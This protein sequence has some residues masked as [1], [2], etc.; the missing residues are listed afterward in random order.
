MPRARAIGVLAAGLAL[1]VLLMPGLFASLQRSFIYFPLGQKAPP[2]A[3]VLP[4]AE[5]VRFQTEDGLTLEAW[6]RAG[7]AGAAT[8]LV[9]N[10]NAGDRSHR[11][12]LA[13]ALA[14]EGFGVLLFDYRGYAG[15]PGT[16]TEDGLMADARAALDHLRSR[17]DVDP[18]R[19][20]YFGESLGA[21][22]AVRLATERAPLALILRS[23]FT[24]LDDMAKLH[25]PW[26]PIGPLLVERYGAIERIGDVRAS[27]LVIAGTADHIV[28]LDHSRRLFDAAR[29]PKRFVA[30]EGAGHN[31]LELLAGPT[32]IAESV[33]AIRDAAGR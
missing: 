21:A 23:P 30:V 26:L 8:V 6:F 31:D 2:I 18:S 13:A 22:V 7:P 17:S 3:G 10:G 11:A 20:A 14:R 5:E 29:E 32:L 24:S 4:G 9:M 33:R 19:I 28:P 16:P 12:P 15:Q 27:V 1:S 25:Y